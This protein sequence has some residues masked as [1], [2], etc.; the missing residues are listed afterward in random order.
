[1]YIYIYIILNIYILIYLAVPGLRCGRQDLLAV[2]CEIYFP[3]QGSNL[4]PLHWEHGVL[5]SRPQEESLFPLP[6]KLGKN[7]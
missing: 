2:A 1:M 6:V 5:A 7:P 4:G 3:E